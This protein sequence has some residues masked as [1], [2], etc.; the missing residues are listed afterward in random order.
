MLLWPLVELEPRLDLDSRLQLSNYSSKKRRRILKIEM[1]RHFSA[2]KLQKTVAENSGEFV[3]WPT[4]GRRGVFVEYLI[5]LLY[6]LVELEF[7]V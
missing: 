2:R 6:E 1:L 3:V 5:T 4:I 7:V